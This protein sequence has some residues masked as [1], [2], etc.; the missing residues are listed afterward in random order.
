MSDARV[1]Y[2]ELTVGKTYY[3][4]CVGQ[5]RPLLFKFEINKDK[6]MIYYP[7]SN[8]E[9]EAFYSDYGIVGCP[10]GRSNTT[11]CL[12]STMEDA[13][14]YINT[15]DYKKHLEDHWES[16]RDWDCLIDLYDRDY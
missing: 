13:I 9:A 6:M 15:D 2:N 4:V 16:V 10:N 1:K 8:F 14:T 11:N 12:F 3:S 7:D 5:I